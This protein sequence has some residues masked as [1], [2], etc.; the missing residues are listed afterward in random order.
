VPAR[1]SIETW[2]IHGENFF[3]LN[4]LTLKNLALLL[5]RNVSTSL[6][7]EQNVLRCDGGTRAALSWVL[8]RIQI[9]H[10]VVVGNTNR[11]GDLLLDLFTLFGP[12]QG[13]SEDV[14]HC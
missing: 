11:G 14:R 5:E 8:S 13:R 7:N 3:A 9:E 6:G 10:H 2:S 4:F 1:S 12:K